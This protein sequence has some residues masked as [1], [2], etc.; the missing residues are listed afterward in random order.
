MSELIEELRFD[1]DSNTIS[2]GYDIDKQ[3]LPIMR[4]KDQILYSLE[5]A[6]T[7]VIVGETGCGKS[8]RKD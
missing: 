3:N 6:S 8:T 5:I 2:A 4:Y 1:K 7:L